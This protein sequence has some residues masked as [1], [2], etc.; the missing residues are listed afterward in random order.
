[1]FPSVSHPVPQHEPPLGIG[2]VDLHGLAGVE[3]V[4]VVR[5]CGV[6]ANSVLSEAEQRVQVLLEPLRE[7]EREKKN[8]VKESIFVLPFF[9]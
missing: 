6:G 5:P 3:G 8:S 4:D 9:T 2:V 7:R 1:V